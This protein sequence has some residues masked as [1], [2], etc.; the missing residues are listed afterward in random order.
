MNAV[1]ANRIGAWFASD[2]AEPC[3]FVKPGGIEKNVSAESN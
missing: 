3:R 1:L 2:E